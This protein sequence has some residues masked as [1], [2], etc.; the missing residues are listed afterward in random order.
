MPYVG[1]VATYRELCDEVAAEGYRGFE[2]SREPGHLP[3][4]HDDGV[5]RPRV[6]A[7]EAVSEGVV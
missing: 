4:A 1:G 5:P 6:P 7:D 3:V 2:L